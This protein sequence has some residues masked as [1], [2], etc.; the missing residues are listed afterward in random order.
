MDDLCGTGCA[1]VVEIVK[2]F[3]N[4]KTL[5]QATRTLGIALMMAVYPIKA[6][7]QGLQLSGG[8]DLRYEAESPGSDEAQV[9]GLFLNARKVLADASG[10]RL[11]LVGQLDAENN[12]EDV[13]LYNTYAQLKGPLGHVNLRLGRYI[14][15]FGL[16]ANY[17]TER[18][19]VQSLEPLSLGIKLDLGAQIL[20]Y[21]G[22]LDYAVSVSQ[23]TGKG[24]NDPDG[25]KLLTTRIGIQGENERAGI[26][27]LNGQ[28]VVDPDEF[29]VPGSFERRR[30]AL[31]GEW[32]WQAWTLRGELISG[33][34]NGKAVSGG[35][36]LADY[37]L[38]PA[39]SLNT[40]LAR[41]NGMIKQ[42]DLVLGFS[43][44]LPRG[45]VIRAAETY[46]RLDTADMRIFSLQ[47]YWEFAHAL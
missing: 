18:L 14:L 42:D 34:D 7:A 3:R 9:K 21:F 8:A 10:D 5:K 15:P 47:L 12:F 25:N 29:P 39:W 24:V 19:L 35:I 11:I 32:S 33:R 30:V 31:D 16:L 40:K 22:P 20:G 44:R 37:E 43:Y 41:W 38:T 28:V 17:D 26:S 13:R 1:V 6:D 2:R 4:V 27:Y 36:L 46:R 23:G 45:F